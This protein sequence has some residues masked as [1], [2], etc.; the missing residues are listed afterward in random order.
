VDTSTGVDTPPKHFNALDSGSMDG[1]RSSPELI[2]SPDS[3][4]LSLMR[5]VWKPGHLSYCDHSALWPKEAKV[6]LKWTLPVARK[7][8]LPL[9]NCLMPT[10][11]GSMQ[12]YQ[13]EEGSVSSA[14][15]GRLRST[16]NKLTS[17]KEPGTIPLKTPATESHRDT[18][19]LCCKALLATV[20]EPICQEQG[21]SA[22]ANICLINMHLYHLAYVLNVESSSF[23]SMVM[24]VSRAGLPVVYKPNRELSLTLLQC[25]QILQD[26]PTEISKFYLITDP[27][28]YKY[29]PGGILAMH[30]E[31]GISSEAKVAQLIALAL[32]QL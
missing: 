14:N 8:Q 21:L 15:F 29:D 4:D 6:L 18:E 11:R 25:G 7:S 16:G 12:D 28:P 3:T 26:I 30:L 2:I 22:A 13:C 5:S 27:D 9:C 1:I 17:G 23:T 32:W 20:V 31:A 10:P 24:Q 19:V